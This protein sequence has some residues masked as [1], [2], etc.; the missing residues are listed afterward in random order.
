MSSV[1]V[2]TLTIGRTEITELADHHICFVAEEA[3][4]TIGPP[5]H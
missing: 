1:A 2:D 3:V 5:L 4:V